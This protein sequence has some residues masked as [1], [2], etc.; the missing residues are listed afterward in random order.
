MPRVALAKQRLAVE[1][2]KLDHVVV[3]NRQRAYAGA[4]KRRNHCAADSARAD[5]ADRHG[6]ELALPD[7]ADL[8]QDNV[9]RIALDLCVGEAHR[10]VE[11]KP[12]APRDLSPS[13]STSRNAAFRTGAGTSWAIRSPRR[14]S[15]GSLPR[16]ARITF[17]SP[18]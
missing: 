15:N 17:T 6:L 16:L 9:P 13:V 12:P 10:P 2:G 11:P 18:R 3:D 1:V 7:A 4:G 8:R 14:T 5:D